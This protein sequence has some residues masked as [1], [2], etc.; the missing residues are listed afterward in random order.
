VSERQAT[1]TI[2]SQQSPT[3]T[4]LPETKIDHSPTVNSQYSTTNNKQIPLTDISDKQKQ[5]RE[6]KTVK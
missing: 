4:R 1:P 3:D 6:K 2:N 5:T